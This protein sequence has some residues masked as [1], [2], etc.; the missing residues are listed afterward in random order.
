[1]RKI[2]PLIGASWTAS[3][4]A[5]RRLGFV[6]VVQVPEARRSLRSRRLDRYP[7]AYG[8][9]LELLA[10]PEIEV[11]HTVHPMICTCL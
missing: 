2:K 1:M 4:E 10:D 11:I 8:S 9:Y 3:Y 5:V 7:V 6:D